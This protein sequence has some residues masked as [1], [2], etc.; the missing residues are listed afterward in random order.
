MRTGP[1]S[2]IVCPQAEQ[3]HVNTGRSNHGLADPRA[4]RVVECVVR[5]GRAGVSRKR[6]EAQQ[7]ADLMPGQAILAGPADVH[8]D[9]VPCR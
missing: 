2:R 7:P 6:A 3:V 9:L 4:D 8:A 5:D 1:Q